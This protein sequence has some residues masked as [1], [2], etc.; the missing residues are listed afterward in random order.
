MSTEVQ[1]H[2]VIKEAKRED[3]PNRHEL[4]RQQMNHTGLRTG[5]AAGLLALVGLS[6]WLLA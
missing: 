4:V 3:K 2:E 6:A 1:Q 5:I